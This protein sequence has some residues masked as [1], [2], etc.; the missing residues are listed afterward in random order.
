MKI[1]TATFVAVVDLGTRISLMFARCRYMSIFRIL[2]LTDQLRLN[3]RTTCFRI[4]HTVRIHGTKIGNIVTDQ[5]PKFNY[6]R[7]RNREVL[8]I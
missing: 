4:Q 3:L 1:R 6:D 7:L 5:Q 8:G 2:L